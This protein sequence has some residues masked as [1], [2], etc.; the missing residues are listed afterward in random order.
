VLQQMNATIGNKNIHAF[1]VTP[2]YR[3]AGNPFAQNFGTPRNAGI[4]PPAGVVINYFVKDAGDS[5]KASVTVMDKDHKEIR[6]FTTDSKE[7]NTKMD[8][9]K[10]MNQFIWDM[11]YPEADRIEGMILWNGNPGTILAPPGNYF[12]K[13]KIGKDSVEVPFAIK[14]DPNY[15]MTQQE[16]QAQF[17]F[18]K[19]VRDK[20]NETQKAIKDIRALRT[21]INS[22]VALQGK[23]APKEIKQMGDSINKQLTSI[24]EILYQTKSKSGQDVLNYPIRLND[25]LSGVFDVA[26]SGNFAPS[27]QAREVYNDLASQ[28][29]AQLARLNAIKQK[30]IPA[31]N[32]LIRQKA[33]P[34]IGVK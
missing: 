13:L 32:E 1:E 23:D 5:T 27:R 17:D 9:A 2:A 8:L 29:D 7:P 12:A 14:A 6:T 18:L 15:K 30:D 4:N 26:G 22:F 16:Y 10:G 34:V 25:K 11:R 33:L 21:Q 24:E 31:F 3:M 20:F 28:I 19:Q